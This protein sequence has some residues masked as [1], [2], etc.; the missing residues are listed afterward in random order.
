[1]GSLRE[2]TLHGVK[3]NAIS[4]VFG[5]ITN[6]LLGIVL[7]RLLSPSDYGIVGM[8]AIFFS[9][10]NIIIDSGFSL[11]LIRKKEITIA[12][13]STV[14]FFN[15]IVSSI[16]CILICFFS[17]E[18]AIF[19]N[20]PRL[21]DI[22]K[23]PAIGLVVGALGTVQWALVTRNVDFK[24][25]ALINM[26]ISVITGLFGIL[27]A[28]LHYGPWALVWSSL[29]GISIKTAYIWIKSTWR[30]KFI[31]SFKSFKSFFSFSGNLVLNSFLDIF[32]NQGMGMIIGK[33]YTPA[34][35]GYYSRGQGTASLPSSFLYSVVE[36]VVFP[37]LSK[38]QDEEERLL[39]VYS[40]FMRIM[41]MAIFFAMALSFAI[42][43]PLFLLLYTDKWEPAIIFMQLFCLNYMFYH[44]HAINWNLLIVKGNTGVAFRKELLNKGIR[45]ALIILS[46]PFGPIYMCAALLLSCIFE[47]FVNTIV[48]GKVTSYRMK[49]QV[50]DF[51]P[52]LVLSIICSAP[53]YFISFFNINPAVALCV[54]IPLA[55]IL[56]FG[57]LVITKNNDLRDLVKTTP[58]SRVNL[59]RKLM[60]VE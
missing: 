56:Y 55:C 11:S 39:L 54:Q 4:S 29:L 8:A 52:Y 40:K 37:V 21:E 42:S 59:L 2:N 27:L 41:S 43:R 10:S 20:E 50:R 15:L 35:L 30:P 28:Y 1:M 6:F 34:Q 45:L 13:T 14:F 5:K 16:C 46:I 17:K 18:I 3:W 36:S 25:P 60:S 57:F 44:I 7:A 23:I 31:F 48:T 19:L 38:I 26:P 33:Y 22:V 24:T 12:D 47:L 32:F 9:L 53:S 49:D 58:L 51:L